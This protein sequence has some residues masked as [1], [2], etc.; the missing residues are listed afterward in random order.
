MG[1]NMK[2]T[3]ETQLKNSIINGEVEEFKSLIESN[4]I[5]INAKG[6][7]GF[8]LLGYTQNQCYYHNSEQNI[9]N[10][11]KKIINILITHKDIDL[12]ICSVGPFI[13]SNDGY[14]PLCFAICTDFTINQDESSI[15]QDEDLV[16]QLIANKKVDLNA[17]S[18]DGKY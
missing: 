17:K 7:D 1:K 10:N 3:L 8:T 5:D 6:E 13:L 2:T 11:Q 9:K 15:Y 18:E 12:N 14:T 4:K 16:D